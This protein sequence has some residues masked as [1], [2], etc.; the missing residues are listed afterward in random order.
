MNLARVPRLS[1]AEAAQALRGLSGWQIVAGKLHR[2][3]TFADFNEAFGFMA[4]AALASSNPMSEA[5][6]APYL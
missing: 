3:Y 2:E 4:R 1:E 6:A 5:L